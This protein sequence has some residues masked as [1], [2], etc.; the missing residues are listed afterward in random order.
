MKLNGMKALLA[1]C[2]TL[3]VYAGEVITRDMFC[4]DTKLIVKDLREKYKEIPVITGKADDEAQSLMT[5][6][7]NPVEE[8]WTI[9]ATNKDYSCIIGVGQKLKVIDYSK[10]KMI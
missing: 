1:S 7:M 4:A 5:I 6:W 8:T 3:N 9:V 10:K 2:L